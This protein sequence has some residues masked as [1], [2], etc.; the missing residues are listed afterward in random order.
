MKKTINTKKLDRRSFL[1][2]TALAGGGLMIG[3]VTPSAFAQGPRGGG[4]AAPVPSNYITINPN[5]TFTIV[6]KNPETGQGIRNALPQIIADELDVDWSQVT[7]KQ[8]DLDPKYG[9]QI[10]GGS[11]A[12]PTNYATMR[13]VGAA[14]RALVLAAAAD[15]WSVP[16]TELTTASGVVRHAASN[17]TATY[18]SLAA[19]AATMPVPATI[20]LKDPK[21]FKIIGKP[22]PGV[23]NLAI[24]TGR[25]GTFS[26]D[27]NPPG[28]LHAIYEKCPVFGGRVVSANIDEIKKLPGIRHAFIVTPPAPPAAAAGAPQGGGRGGGGGGVNIPSGVAIVA[29]N[30]WLAQNARKSLKIVWNEG[31]TASQSTVGYTARAKE[32]A[33]AAATQPSNPPAAPAAAA[34]AAPGAPQGGGRGGGAGASVV[35]DVDAAFAAAGNKVV[36]AEYYFPL[37]AHAPL[38]PMNSTAHFQN[39]KLEIWSPSQIPNAGNA[40]AAAGVTA[41]DVTMHLVRAGGGFGRRLQS[42]YDL[43]VARIARLVADERAAAGQPSVPVKVLWSRE[44][45]MHFDNYRPAAYHNFKGAV[46][47]S[48]KL[49]AFKDYVGAVTSTPIP[50]NEFPRGFVANFAVSSGSITPFNIP[51]GALRA[52]GTNGTTFAMQSIIDELAIAANKDPLQFRLD[53]LNS[54]IGTGLQGFSAARAIGVVEK[55]RQMSNWNTRR[56]SLPRG[57]GMGVA[58]QFAHQGYVAYVVE[59]AVDANKRIKINKA[60]AAVDIGRQIVNPSMAKNLVEGGFIEGM[61][62]VMHWE[63]TIDKGR[64]VQNNFGEFQPTRMQQVARNLV[65]VEFVLSDNNPTGLGEPSLPPAVPAITNAIF[66]ATGV[67]IRTVPLVH[68]GYSWAT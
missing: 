40:G 59:A 15:N 39:G 31:A 7:I 29:D 68:S 10:E 5:N 66:H 58:F 50:S 26:I 41:A 64:V 43:E 22:L 54:Q 2:V 3:M 18:G 36:S 12:I 55:V 14:G 44:D 8:A 56:G 46:D 34:A 27:Q 21:D 62:H 47:A 32:L 28:M 17:R 33:A 49:V 16:V 51:T 4:G 6:A 57:T 63:I 13:Q 35:G 61:S 53:T 42:E 9:S 48:G 25:A 24:V 19:K 11:T 60:W 65:D 45:D 23:D 20:P 1:Q 67:R 37:L 52:P 38:E 30:W